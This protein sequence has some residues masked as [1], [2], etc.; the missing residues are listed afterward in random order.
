MKILLIATIALL[1]THTNSYAF[2]NFAID[3]VDQNKKKKIDLRSGKNESS[4]FFEAT[5]TNLIESNLENAFKS[6]INFDEKC[7]NEFKHKRKLTP[8]EKNCK[9]FN[10]N[11]VESKRED[12]T[13]EY[14]KD[15]NETQRFLI[16]RNIHNRGDY[17]H[18]DLAKV[19]EYKNDKNQRV[20]KVT[21]DMLS[22]NDLK[23]YLG[24]NAAKTESVFQVAYG[25][26]VLTE[27][28]PAQTELQYLYR[29]VTDHWLVNKIVSVP[30]VFGT[31]SGT[32][33]DLM[34]S[35]NQET[36]NLQEEKKNSVRQ[37]ANKENN[38]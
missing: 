9:Y 35:I 25:E 16:K 17:Y 29:N 23:K 31:M 14:E 33:H 28:S 5:T 26:F 4:R 37:L 8:R 3:S 13:I 36:K 20:I 38:P 1:N 34:K 19:Y 30:K 11:L 24:P 7:N 21:H 10:N 18:V 6:V 32:I 2:E 22:D 12:I 15:I 27:I